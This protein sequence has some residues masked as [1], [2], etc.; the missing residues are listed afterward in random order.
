MLLF[1][2]NLQTLREEFD[3]LPL[4]SISDCC[5]KHRPTSN[6]IK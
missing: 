2:N 3:F 6:F 4:A 1:K 5:C